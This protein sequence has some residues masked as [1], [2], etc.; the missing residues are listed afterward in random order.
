MFARRR[1]RNVSSAASRGKKKP[2][3]IVLTGRHGDAAEYRG[4]AR[5]WGG[6]QGGQTMRLDM[7]I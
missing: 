6:G 7:G 5:G 3:N 2:W 4:L 1:K